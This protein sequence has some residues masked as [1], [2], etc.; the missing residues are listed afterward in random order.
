MISIACIDKNRGIGKDGKLLISIPEDMKFFRETTKDSIVIMGRKTLYSFKDKMPL[1]NRINI[2]FTSDKDFL[3][4]HPEYQNL[5]NIF[6]VNNKNEMNNILSKY[7]DKKAF[8][9]GGADIYNFLLDECDTL[10]LTELDTVLEADSYFPDFLS[11]GFIL[12]NKSETFQYE[13]INY[14]FNT[15]IK[16]I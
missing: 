13:D 8:V 11:N 3:S 5:D 2:V 10:L 15:Y 6:F 7:P 1:K 14:T 4:K 9:I 12:K 16:N